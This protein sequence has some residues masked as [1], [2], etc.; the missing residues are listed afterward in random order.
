MLSPSPSISTPAARGWRS[1]SSFRR[2][3][4]LIC[5]GPLKNSPLLW[6]L[7]WRSSGFFNGAR[8]PSAQ[9]EIIFEKSLLTWLLMPADC[10]WLLVTTLDAYVVSLADTTT[11]PNLVLSGLIPLH[12]PTDITALGC[13]IGA[14]FFTTIRELLGPVEPSLHL[15]RATFTFLSWLSTLLK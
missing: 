11:S 13:K 1:T 4:A 6:T 8:H 5:S 9:F 3:S 2:H 7:I 15:S 10:S 12:A 14:A